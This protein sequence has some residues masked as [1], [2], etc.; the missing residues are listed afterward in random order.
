MKLYLVIS[1]FLFCST[2]FAESK[3]LNDFFNLLSEINNPTNYHNYCSTEQ[4]INLE[5]E[6]LFQKCAQDLCG[7][8]N[9]VKSAY[10]SD[11]NFDKYIDKIKM[12]K[13]EEN[14]EKIKEKLE[15][16]LKEIEK[17]VDLFFEQ[18]KDNLEINFDDWNDADYTHFQT[19]F[20]D[21]YEIEIDNN[22]DIEHRVKITYVN[23]GDQS[24]TLKAGVKD[25]SK[26]HTERIKNNFEYGLDIGFYTTEEGIEYAKSLINN[27]SLPITSSY[28]ER[29]NQDN[30][31]PYD[32]ID[33]I[34]SIYRLTGVEIDYS[35]LECLTENCKDAIKERVSK[36]EYYD[37]YKQ[38]KEKISNK[39]LF[40]EQR[41]NFCK[42]QFA[43][44]QI[45]K[46]NQ[47]KLK[48]SFKQA[49]NSFIKK[50]F[51]I[52]SK[53]T[54]EGLL[55]YF[56]NKLD[57][58]Y[59]MD[60]ENNSDSFFSN[61]LNSSGSTLASNPSSIDFMMYLDN[62]PI[63]Q[64]PC[65]DSLSPI[66]WD[67]FVPSEYN[68]FEYSD[69]DK[70]KDNIMASHFT[71][72]HGY[73]GES[74]ISHELGHAISYYFTKKKSSKKSMESF[75]ELRLCATNL[76]KDGGEPLEYSLYSLPG[77]R[78]R[79][80]EDMADLYSYMVDKSEVNTLVECSMLKHTSMNNEFTDLSF[81]QSFIGDGHSSS[82]MRLIQEAIHKRKTMPNSCSQLIQK[83]KQYYRF[84]SC[85]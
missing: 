83:N 11:A 80:E 38:L 23:L 48:N 17:S 15:D 16:Q 56:T 37:K 64:L 73:Q 7:K 19:F 32:I 44:T 39:E 66:M 22:V 70:Q 31:S 34:R 79:T 82:F 43:L 10:L 35:G 69:I 12:D 58:Y 25:F 1:I 46:S 29:L 21:Y 59:Q 40:I 6:S 42:S 8:P 3:Y 9:E 47:E 52:Y 45:Q 49:K 54:Q 67:S 75:M 50:V 18:N 77:D 36:K 13:F 27:S 28:M 57:I 60:I 68:E 20:R 53:E 71:C 63:S 5:D 61:T 74:I 81:K 76:Y 62:D 4:D 24:E 51:P 14:K 33:I 41:L 72:N 2:V 65:G 26:L 84:K 85:F 55:N 30:L 78:L